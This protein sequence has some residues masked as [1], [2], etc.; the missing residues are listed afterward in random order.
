MRVATALRP[1]CQ[2]LLE[3]PLSFLALTLSRRAMDQRRKVFAVA[4]PFAFVLA[5]AVV[6][7]PAVAF[8]LA[9]A[10]G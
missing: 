3:G 7:A 2:F 8:A 6:F 10:V 9:V 5:V 4:L 1:K